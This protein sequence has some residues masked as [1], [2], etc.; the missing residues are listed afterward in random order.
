M[1]EYRIAES[2]VQR[3]HMLA[4]GRTVVGDETASPAPRGWERLLASGD[5]DDVSIEDVAILGEN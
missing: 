2:Y 5:G 1:L 4:H 3:Y